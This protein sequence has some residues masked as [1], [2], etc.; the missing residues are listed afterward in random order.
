MG[1][2]KIEPYGSVSSMPYKDPEKQR[3]AQRRHYR[4]NIDRYSERNRRYASTLADQKRAHTSKKREY[5]YAAK[6]GPCMDC[7]G[8]FHHSA[9]DFH[10]R[11]P[12]QKTD[13][14]SKMVVRGGIERLKEEIAKCDL[15]CANC[16]RIRHWNEGQA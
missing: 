2:F 13:S 15:I 16:H 10:H 6:D 12:S 7:G 3:E 11:D 1:F 9:M 8:S 14:I 5:V 4:E